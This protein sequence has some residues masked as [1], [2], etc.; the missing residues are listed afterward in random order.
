M[1]ITYYELSSYNNGTPISETFTLDGMTED[2]H[3][4][5][6]TEWLSGIGGEE[7]AMVD[8]E[9][10]P[11]KFVEDYG[12]R[13]E[14][15]DYADMV[16][17]IGLSKEVIDAGID[18]DLSLDNIEDAY[19]GEY[20]SDVDFAQGQAEE[21]GLLKDVSEWPYNHIDWERAARDLMYDHASSYGHYFRTYR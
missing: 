15:W 9:G 16:S 2:E 10:I 13:S 17:G 21:C 3:N 12:L 6:V 8:N 19:V 4:E 5:M 1:D 20:K 7:F 14:F 18:C 11:S